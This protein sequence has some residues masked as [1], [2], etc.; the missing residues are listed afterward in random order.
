MLFSWH[1]HQCIRQAARELRT[2]GKKQRQSWL[3]AQLLEAEQAAAKHDLGAVYRV[4]NSI[5]PKRRRDKVRI[6][7]KQGHL[8]SVKQEFEDILQHFTKAFSSSEKFPLTHQAPPLSFTE[9][10]VQA[11]I[12]QLKRGKSVPAGSLPADIWLLDPTGHGKVVYPS[13]SINAALS[14]AAFLLKPRTANSHFC[15]SR[16]V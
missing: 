7:S 15:R 11:A 12:L 5:A 2:A 6:R 10:E 1:R 9:S 14:I 8:M 16:D 13:F 3:D 4:V